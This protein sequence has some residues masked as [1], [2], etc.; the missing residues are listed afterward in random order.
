MTLTRQRANG[1][2]VRKA[3]GDYLVVFGAV[4][5]A[6]ALKVEIYNLTA[7]D[8]TWT[9]GT[10]MTHGKRYTTVVPYNNSFLTVGGWEHGNGAHDRLDFFDPDTMTFVNVLTLPWVGDSHPAM[11]VDYF[12]AVSISWA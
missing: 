5:Q 9:A 2:V 11:L 6:D 4:D 10:D 8:G 1:G 12:M 3:D 7:N